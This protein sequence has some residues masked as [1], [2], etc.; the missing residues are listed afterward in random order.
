MTVSCSP[1]EAFQRSS[2]TGS[3]GKLRRSSTVRNLKM[4]MGWL[5][6]VSEVCSIGRGVASIVAEHKRQCGECYRDGEDE[7]DESEGMH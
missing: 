5:R 6:C 3:S 4:A 7:E 2:I 1:R